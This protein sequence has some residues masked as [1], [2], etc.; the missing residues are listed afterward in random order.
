MELSPELQERLKN[1]SVED[2]ER[3]TV[4]SREELRQSILDSG[5]TEDRQAPRPVADRA[6]LYRQLSI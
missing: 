3:L 2:L 1:L 5:F 6:L 4:S